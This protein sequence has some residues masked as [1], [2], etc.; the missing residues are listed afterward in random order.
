MNISL[1]IRPNELIEMAD[2]HAA[3]CAAAIS[4]S[5]GIAD[6]IANDIN[7][8]LEEFTAI[9]IKLHAVNTLTGLPHTSKVTLIGRNAKTIAEIKITLSKDLE[10]SQAEIT[11][12]CNAST[13]QTTRIADKVQANAEAVYFSIGELLKKCMRT[14][15]VAQMGLPKET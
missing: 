12:R 11:R 6:Q 7:L 5:R 2:D 15:I 8:A 9:G 14:E 1:G 4:A 13:F 3:Q 10:T